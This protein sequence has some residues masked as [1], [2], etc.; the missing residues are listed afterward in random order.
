M[1]LSTLPLHYYTAEVFTWAFINHIL[2]ASDI[3]FATCMQG[4]SSAEKNAKQWEIL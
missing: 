3:P 4:A 1:V 2:C